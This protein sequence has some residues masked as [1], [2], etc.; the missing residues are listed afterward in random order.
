MCSRIDV[1]SSEILRVGHLFIWVMLTETIGLDNGKAYSKLF[2]DIKSYL[3]Y[4][5][6]NFYSYLPRL[7][8]YGH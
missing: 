4:T 6:N 3:I 5:S 7:L 1:I 2:G 8:P